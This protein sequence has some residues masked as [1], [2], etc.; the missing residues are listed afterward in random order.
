MILTETKERLELFLSKRVNEHF[1]GLVSS[2]ILDWYDDECEPSRKEKQYVIAQTRL[3]NNTKN[4][5]VLLCPDDFDFSCT[6]VVVEV[7]NKGDTVVWNR[8]GF[9]VTPYS[10]S[11]TEIPSYYWWKN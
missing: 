1:V 2:W 5:P 6:C 4:L 10:P 8:F 7:I 11:T 3:E 9:D